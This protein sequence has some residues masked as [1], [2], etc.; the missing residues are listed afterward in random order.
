MRVNSWRG[1]K[2]NPIRKWR[3][4]EMAR[5]TEVSFHRSMQ[6][7][8]PSRPCPPDPDAAPFELLTNRE[9]AGVRSD[10]SQIISDAVNVNE[11]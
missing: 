10:A 3:H 6:S 5:V 4:G 2:K 7:T 1:R 8:A 9:R 11:K